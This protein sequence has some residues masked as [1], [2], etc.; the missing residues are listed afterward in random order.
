LERQ[1]VETDSTAA[2][3]QAPRA[4]VVPTN[5]PRDLSA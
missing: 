3:E 5:S 1:R 4:Q 2:V